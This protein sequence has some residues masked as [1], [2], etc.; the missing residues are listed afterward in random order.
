MLVHHIDDRHF[1]VQSPRSGISIGDMG[2]HN[3]R[4]VGQFGV[5]NDIICLHNHH[6]IIF[7]CTHTPSVI[8]LYLARMHLRQIK[9]NRRHKYNNQPGHM[10]VHRA[11]FDTS[12]SS[13]WSTPTCRRRRL[14]GKAILL[15]LQGDHCQSCLR[16]GNCR[17]HG[18]FGDGR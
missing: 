11:A 18:Q 2:C 16:S 15:A 12:R 8:G 13:I 10:H 14:V 6:K 5:G 7:C 4:W 1:Q 17:C 9:T 3:R